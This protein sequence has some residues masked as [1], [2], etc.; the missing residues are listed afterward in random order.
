MALTADEETAVR[1]LLAAVRKLPDVPT[2]S[3][4]VQIAPV[5]RA[6]AGL[7]GFLRQVVGFLRKV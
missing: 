1:A 3:A 2:W 5:Q 7:E 6:L 4:S